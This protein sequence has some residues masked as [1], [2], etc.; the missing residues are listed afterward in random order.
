MDTNIFLISTGE[1]ITREVKSTNGEIIGYFDVVVFVVK[2]STGNGRIVEVPQQAVRVDQLDTNIFL[3]SVDYALENFD[4]FYDT[5][6]YSLERI[7]E[8]FPACKFSK[9]GF[10]SYACYPEAKPEIKEMCE[11]FYSNS[12]YLER[13]QSYV[14]TGEILGQDPL[15]IIIEAIHKP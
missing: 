8:A 1:A 7:S 12:D 14:N 2:D 6:R 5:T 13:L 10:S 11:T 9:Y 3:N 15:L 4:K